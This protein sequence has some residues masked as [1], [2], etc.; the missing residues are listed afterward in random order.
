MWK[1]KIITVLA[2]GLTVAGCSKFYGPAGEG[3]N[4]HLFGVATTQNINA[5]IAYGDPASRIRALNEAFRAE[6]QD[7]VTFEFN[8]SALDSS[9]HAALRQQAKWL[10]EHRFVRMTVVGHTDKVGSDAYN[11]RL[12]MRRAQAVVAYL[13]SRGI[14]RSRLDAVESRGKRDPVV[15]TD[16]RERRNRRSVT[17]VAGFERH[18][19]GDGL[20]GKYAE[21]VFKNY[22]TGKVTVQ[23]AESTEVN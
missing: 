18:Y 21:R 8:R 14:S 9:A 13:V 17:S 12:G 1:M 5:Q 7:T 22:V 23:E 3:R 20:N 6:A 11:D 15:Q 16:G 19:V 2:A 4:S 10:K